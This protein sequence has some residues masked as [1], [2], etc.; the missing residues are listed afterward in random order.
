MLRQIAAYR[1]YEYRTDPDT[2]YFISS[3]TDINR[4]A[5]AVRSHWAIENQLHW[6]LDVIFDEDSSKV[7][8]DMSPLNL[9]VLR[10][11]A[12]ALCKRANLGRRPSIQ[13]KRFAAALNPQV[14]LNILFAKL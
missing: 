2:R 10:K 9:N 12:L 3:L 11:T 7:R 13:K 4:F 14:F 5:H 6:A 1:H 8:K